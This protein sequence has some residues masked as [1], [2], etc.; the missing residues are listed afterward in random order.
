MSH[1]ILDR[2]LKNNSL[3][4]V[5]LW[6]GEEEFLIRRALARLEEWLGQE[7][8][9]AAKIVL[10][11]LETPLA[12]VL[13][14]AR[15]PQL[16]GGRQLVVVWQVERYKSKEL[17]VL[18]KY[19]QAPS[20]QTCLVLI[21]PG[22]KPKEIQAH[23]IWGR[24]LEQEAALGFP[25]LR[26][27]E[28][29]AWL[30]REAKRQ[31][32]TLGPGAARQ[33]VEVV[34]QNLLELHQELEK[35][36]LYTG[37]ET[38]ITGTDTAR[39]SSHSRAH[40]IFELVE[41]LGQNRP[42]KALKVLGRL[43]ELGEPASVIL[44]MLARQIRLLMGTREGL[45]RRLDATALA[46]ELGVPRFVAEKLQRQ[47]GSFRLAQLKGQLIR[48]HEADQQIKTGMAVPRLLLEKFILDLCP[49]PALKL[50]PREH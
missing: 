16:W 36:I 49:L 47:A 50:P 22:L 48:L 42:D 7:E 21:A 17:A 40:T 5:Y 18:E 12:E 32:K 35:L 45:K 30:E 28:L 29:P 39:L 46:K 44:V 38:T 11:G 14:E 2:H 43:L 37:A 34:G 1:P 27:G 3:K 19:L 25:R 41:A 20:G 23:A 9:L 13:T 15:S 24:L 31:G 26:E 6:Y 8:E 33:L 10:D 4:P